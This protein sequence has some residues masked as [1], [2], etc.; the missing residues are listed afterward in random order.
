MGTAVAYLVSGNLRGVS[1]GDSEID[2]MNMEKDENVAEDLNA[3][4]ESLG[5]LCWKQEVLHGSAGQL[6]ESFIQYYST[7]S[8]IWKRP[9]RYE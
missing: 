5:K 8:K 7:L 2:N 6:Q 9:R 1:E 4:K 3:E